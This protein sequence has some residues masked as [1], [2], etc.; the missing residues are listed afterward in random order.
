LRL[1]DNNI[2]YDAIA[3]NQGYW[4]KEMPTRIDVVYSIERNHYNGNIYKQLRVKDLK[5]AK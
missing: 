4:G 3:F 2:E 1:K 5:P